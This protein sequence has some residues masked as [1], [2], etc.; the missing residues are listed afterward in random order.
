MRMK[1]SNVKQALT[2]KVKKINQLQLDE[3]G[4]VIPGMPYQ[5]NVDALNQVNNTSLASSRNPNQKVSKAINDRSME[6]AA[7]AIID[8][9]MVQNAANISSTN[10]SNLRNLSNKLTAGKQLSY[11]RDEKNASKLFNKKNSV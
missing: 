3:K 1:S 8:R 4:R 7:K 10:K 5:E 11:P 6:K 9:T 2:S